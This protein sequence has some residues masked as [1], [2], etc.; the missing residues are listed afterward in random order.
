[1]FFG[2]NFRKFKKILSF[3]PP[4]PWWAIPHPANPAP[5]SLFVSELNYKNSLKLQTC[6]YFIVVFFQ[7]CGEWGWNKSTQRKQ[8][9]KIELRL[10]WRLPADLPLHKRF[11]AY[12]LIPLN[13]VW[14]VRSVITWSLEIIK[15]V[16]FSWFLAPLVA[17]VI[18]NKSLSEVS[19]LEQDTIENVS[20]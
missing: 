6:F 11:A 4:K 3:R 16:I 1:M 9:V 20:K 19:L 2:I 13:T 17:K 10:I 5:T 8:H 18:I 12:L 7:E 14:T 15:P